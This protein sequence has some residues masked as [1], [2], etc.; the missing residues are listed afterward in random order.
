MKIRTRYFPENNYF[1]IYKDGI[2]YRFQIEDDLPIT[3]LSYPEFLDLKITSFCRGFCNWCFPSGTLIDCNGGKI[4]IDKIKV[5]DVVK[6]FDEK[7]ST[8]CNSR[9][10]ETLKNHYVGKLVVLELENGTTLRVTPNHNI[11]TSRGWVE[12]Q[13]IT[14]SDELI[15]NK[16]MSKLW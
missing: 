13:Y 12:A 16:T 5:N 7:L 1:A 11:L 3:K 14:E 10:C 8:L 4:A 9:V 6:S 2:S 15:E